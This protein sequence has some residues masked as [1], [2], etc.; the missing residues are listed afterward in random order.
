M[1]NRVVVALPQPEYSALLQV[2]RDEL[3]N[4]SDQLRVILRK[5]LERHGLLP[6]EQ[7]QESEVENEPQR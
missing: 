6:A 1:I 7:S 2:A 3:R 5:E 4:P